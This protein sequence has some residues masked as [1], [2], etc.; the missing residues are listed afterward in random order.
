MKVNEF[1]HYIELRSA[2]CNGT[3]SV[4]VQND[5]SQI[6]LL[7]EDDVFDSFIDTDKKELTA[8]RDILNKIIEWND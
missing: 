7:T 1:K 6:R 2:D 3:W 8:L 5:C 4:Q